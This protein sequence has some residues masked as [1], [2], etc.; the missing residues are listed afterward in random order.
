M[1]GHGKLIM[2][3]LLETKATTIVELTVVPRPRSLSSSSPHFCRF[4][5]H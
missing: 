4:P 1:D 5:A 3:C 2:E